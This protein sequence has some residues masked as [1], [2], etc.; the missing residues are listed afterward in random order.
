MTALESLTTIRFPSLTLRSR[1]E[2]LLAHLVDVRAG[3]AVG[4]LLASNLF[5][6]LG[7]Y[8]L[9]KTAG[10]ALILS[11]GHPQEKRRLGVRESLRNPE[12]EAA[13]Y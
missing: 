2:R 9:L 6:L 5:L 1:L 8:Y 4:A 13:A 3:E 10:A 12:I 7:A 11:Q